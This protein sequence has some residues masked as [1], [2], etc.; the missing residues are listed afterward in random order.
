MFPFAFKYLQNSRCIA[1]Q[2]IIGLLIGIILL[3]MFV[4]CTSQR[5]LHLS[6]RFLSVKRRLLHLSQRLL[7]VR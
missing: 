3:P 4:L 7:S 1:Y 2:S 5:L 6:Q